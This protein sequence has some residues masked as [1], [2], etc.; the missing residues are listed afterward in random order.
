M[1]KSAA[2]NYFILIAICAS[3]LTYSCSMN[4]LSLKKLSGCWIPDKSSQKIIPLSEDGTKITLQLKA[5]G[6]FTATVPD[7]LMKT[8]DQCSGKVISGKGTWSILSEFFKNEINLRFNEINGGKINWITNKIQVL[9]T[10]KDYE[11]FF[12]IGEEGGDRFVFTR[13]QN[14]K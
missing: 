13:L 4:K 1:K 6:R 2:N 5:D 14:Q 11:L 12:Y 3:I 7:Y 8:S 9:T 10:G